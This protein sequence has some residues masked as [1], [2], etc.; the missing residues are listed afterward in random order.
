MAGLVATW[1]GWIACHF[2]IVAGVLCLAT[3][4]MALLWQRALGTG[5]SATALAVLDRGT[6]VALPRGVWVGA[7]LLLAITAGLVWSLR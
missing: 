3:M 6:A 4:A 2:T 7:G 1:Q 5:P